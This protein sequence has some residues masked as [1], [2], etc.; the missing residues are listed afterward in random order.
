MSVDVS[1]GLALGMNCLAGK[2]HG[3][4][5]EIG[6]V[7]IEGV[8]GLAALFGIDSAILECIVQILGPT[9]RGG[10][11]T[12]LLFA[13]IDARLPGK[14]QILEEN[15]PVTLK[16]RAAPVVHQDRNMFCVLMPPRQST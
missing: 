14:L 16:V 5:V 7:V 3:R 13:A 12:T 6:T 1:D 15:D 2:V 4:T 9:W 10:R 8:A 11:P